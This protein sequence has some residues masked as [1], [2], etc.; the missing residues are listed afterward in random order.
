MGNKKSEK[1]LEVS[2]VETNEGGSSDGRYKDEF[3]ENMRVDATIKSADKSSAQVLSGIAQKFSLENVVKVVMGEVN[4]Q[5]EREDNNLRSGKCNGKSVFADEYGRFDISSKVF[6][7]I[8]LVAADFC[9]H[10]QIERPNKEVFQKKELDFMSSV[11]AV[12]QCKRIMEDLNILYVENPEIYALD[13]ENLQKKY[14]E[15][16][17]EEDIKE[18]IKRGKFYAKEKWEKEDE[19]YYIIFKTKLADIPVASVGYEE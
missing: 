10:N 16:A 6:D 8:G 12:K 9:G 18:L 15:V 14:D 19:G 13:Y 4:I 2:K 17:K 7:T 3:L 5:I 11:D 1:G